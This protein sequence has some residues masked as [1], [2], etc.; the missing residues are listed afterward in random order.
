MDQ[1]DNIEAQNDSDHGETGY[2]H[3]TMKIKAFRYGHPSNSKPRIIKVR[4]PRGYEADALAS[5]EAKR[6]NPFKAKKKLREE[7]KKQAEIEL[8]KAEADG[9]AAGDELG[10]T[11][12][13]RVE[14]PGLNKNN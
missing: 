7:K 4:S 1:Y 2:G 5:K 10:G 6:L 3:G 8:A 9:T 11:P 12:Q 14:S 13:G